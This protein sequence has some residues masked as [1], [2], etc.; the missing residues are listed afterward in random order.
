MLDDA[1]RRLLSLLQDEGRLT[2]AELAERVGLSLSACHRRVKRL[3]EEGFIAGYSAVVDRKSIGFS[4]LAY[5]FVKLEAH[6]E[7]FLKAF[8]EGVAKIDEIVACYA[9]AGGG[10]YLLKV[11][12][13]DMDAY[14]EVALKKIVRLPGVKD[15]SSNFVLTTLKREAGWPVKG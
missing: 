4:V 3:E 5:V 6:S 12:A 11:V 14:A 9:I 8:V 15:S 7:D 10:D 13:R 2:N 1:D